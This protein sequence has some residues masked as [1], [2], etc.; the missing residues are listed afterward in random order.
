MRI[1]FYSIGSH[2]F[3]SVTVKNAMNGDDDEHGE[4]REVLKIHDDK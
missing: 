1:H 4:K 2:I 3:Y